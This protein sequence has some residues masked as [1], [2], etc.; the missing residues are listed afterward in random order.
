MDMNIVK[1]YLF[2]DRRSNNLSKRNLK[3]GETGRKL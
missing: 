2:W 3:A 1:L